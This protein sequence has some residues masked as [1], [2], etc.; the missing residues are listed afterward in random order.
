VGEVPPIAT[1]GVSGAL[2]LAANKSIRLRTRW[3]LL[4]EMEEAGLRT[5]TQLPPGTLVGAG[6][7]IIRP[8]A[9]G[10]MGAVFEVEQLATGAHRALKVM[11]LQL[12]SDTRLRARFVR[13]ARVGVTIPSDHVA[14]VLDA[15]VDERTDL[16][17]FVLELLDGV[18]LSRELRRRGALEWPLAREVFRQLGHAVAAAHAEKIVHRDLKPGNIFLAR[19][20]TAGMPFVLKVLDFGIAEI[21]A[22]V[23]NV[24][25]GAGFFGTP[26]WMAPEQANPHAPVGPTADVWALGLIAFSLFTGRAYWPMANIE[27]AP[28]GAMLRRL[29]SEEIVP[30]SLRAASYRTEG[31]SILPP[32][33]DAWFL[34][35]VDRDPARR[36]E[37]AAAASAEFATM[38]TLAMG[39]GDRKSELPSILAM[40]DSQDE[41]PAA[42]F[43][44]E[45]TRAPT[46]EAR[47]AVR[48]ARTRRLIAAAVGGAGLLGGSL[49]WWFSDADYRRPAP[50]AALAGAAAS[51]S[52][53]HLLARLHG[54]N[55]IGAQLGPALAEAFLRR[56]T[57]GAPVRK[58]LADDEMWVEARTNEGEVDAIEIHAHGSSTAFDDLQ[59]GACD[60]GMA[61]RR[62]RPTEVAALADL[63]PMA[64]AATEHVI[65]LDG[66]AVLVNPSNPVDGL[67][68]EQL[69]KIYAGEITRWSDV[70]GEAAPVSLYAR[71]DRSGTF[72]TFKTLVLGARPLATATRRYES[73]DALADAVAADPN[74]IGFVGLPYVRSAKAV[75]VED[76]RAAPLLPSPAT[77]ATE[78]YPLSRRLYLYAP[79]GAPASARRF[80]DFALSDD[81]QDIVSRQGFVDLRPECDPNAAACPRCGNELKKAVASSCRLSMNFRFDPLTKQLDTRALRD[82]PRLAG[83]LAR[84]EPARVGSE[85]V[86][87][88][89]SARELAGRK[90]LLFGFSDATGRRKDEIALSQQRAETVKAQLQARGV[91]VAAARGFGAE[92]P[93]ADEADEAGRERN[94]RVEVWLR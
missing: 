40:S 47:T 35:C 17:F 75:M 51:P 54:S 19:S 24:H 56:E 14:Q 15:G 34:R 23:A 79:P 26:T 61:S 9:D 70:G 62:I 93:V 65:A 81:G 38:M 44:D 29:A 43:N 50:P 80:V 85:G 66:I 60:V 76:A 6:Y 28:T 7:R 39:R 37:D 30:A 4:P 58:R 22:S 45:P 89:E 21:V 46:L 64:S 74:A 82:L 32:G 67:T 87:S 94:R 27:A 42:T 11:H 86:L 31:G 41:T 33:F 78:D 5:Q 48:R 88:R 84:G 10:G 57:G 36:F 52:R 63:G 1:R 77:V 68:K 25:Q 16:P 69:A 18:T 72:D 73:S 90:V 12:A 71:D 91:A 59:S 55:T 53:T 92:M 49:F 8:I 83:L 3:G 2:P 13:E 20:K